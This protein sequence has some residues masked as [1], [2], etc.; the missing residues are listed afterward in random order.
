MK[1]AIVIV[2]GKSPVYGDFKEPVAADGSVRGNESSLSAAPPSQTS[3]RC[4]AR[5]N[6][7]KEAA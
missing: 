4:E 2:A 7:V 6:A 3:R 5:I 1:A